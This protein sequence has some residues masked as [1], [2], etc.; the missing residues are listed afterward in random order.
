MSMPTLKQWAESHEP[1]AVE[2]IHKR[3]MRFAENTTDPATSLAAN[4][5]LAMIQDAKGK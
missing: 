4:E 1:V 2:R 3:L 5:L